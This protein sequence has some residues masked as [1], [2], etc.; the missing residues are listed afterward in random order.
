M[1]RNSPDLAADARDALARRQLGEAPAIQLVDDTAIAIANDAQ[2]DPSALA[3]EQIASAR[4]LL[5]RDL[6]SAPRWAWPELDALSGPM[7]PG[8]FIVPGAYTGTGKTSLLMSQMD[9]FANTRVP[10][11]YVPLEV[12][13][14]VCRL[15]WAAW[16]LNLDVRHVVRQ[17]WAALPESSRE[18]VDGV[19]E[20][21]AAESLIHFATPKRMTW[22]VLKRWCRWA[23][24]KVG[25]RVVMLDHF[26]RL[27]FGAAATWRTDITE[28]ARQ[29]KDLARDLE[30]VM[31][32]AAQLNRVGND[33]VDQYTAPSL[34]R[35]KESAGIGEEADV[36]LMLSRRLRPELPKG[37]AQDLRLGR[38]SEIDIAEPNTMV[39]TCRKHRLDGDAMNRSIFLTVDNGRV[40]SR[41]RYGP[42]LFDGV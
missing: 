27:T 35:I 36:V 16:K 10:V 22:D 24:E 7:M 42:G 12:D 25:V 15:R 34:A 11:L 6:S 28:M 37:W 1:R 29:V 26:H 17:D 31:L 18:A 38:K 9:A 14:A 21:Q 40:R 19:L 8:D 30:V 2:P 3:A 20:E 23:V 5:T 13:P 32:A 39:I 41:R 33:P 4:T